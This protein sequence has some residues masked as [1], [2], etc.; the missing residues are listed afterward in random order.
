[1]EDQFRLYS[2][3]SVLVRL[4]RLVGLLLTAY[5]LQY[6]PGRQST[7]HVNPA[8]MPSILRSLNLNASW[9][10]S[11]LLREFRVSKIGRWK[12]SASQYTE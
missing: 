1:M 9:P 6:A 10:N 5:R 4:P 11:H 8:R 12:K 3:V 2:A 7:V